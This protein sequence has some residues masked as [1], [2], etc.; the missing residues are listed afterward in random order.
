[1]AEIPS[2]FRT[3]TGKCEESALLDG[4]S[5]PPADNREGCEALTP[6]WRSILE[7]LQASLARSQDEREHLARALERTST[8][9]HEQLVELDALRNARGAAESGNLV[10]GQMLAMIGRSMRA[11]VDAVL[12][13]TELLRSGRLPSPQRSY[14]DAMR[15]A[16]ETLKATLDDVSDFSR[17]ESGTLPLEPIEFDV[18]VLVYDFAATLGGEAARRNVGLQVR[19]EREG[20]LRVTGDPGRIR[21]VLAAIVRDAFARL[22]GGEVTVTVT[23]DPARSDWSRT[24]IS[25]EDSGPA[26]PSDLLATIF[27][28][29]MPFESYAHPGGSL[30]LPIARQLAHLMGG[31]LVVENLPDSGSRFLLCLPLPP[32]RPTDSL[33]PQFDT[34]AAQGPGQPPRGRLLVVE[35]DASLRDNWIE[36]ARAAGY[37]PVGCERYSEARAELRRSSD[38]GCPFAVVVFSDHDA[39]AYADIG[40]EITEDHD[41]DKPALLMLP[42]VGNPGD[43]RRLRDAGFRGYLVKPVAPADLRETLETLRRTSRSTWHRLFLTRHALAEARRGDENDAGSSS[44]V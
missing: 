14:A 22:E 15:E 38:E 24:R 23:S 41:L 8:E 40:R 42:A 21:Q 18:R 5:K 44:S 39:E 10:R 36:I 35:A 6:G 32:V 16:A 43:G 9:L 26:I 1:M 33:Q 13:L 7:S 28:P 37:R 17:L 12:G 19:W 25:I 29:F 34:S 31:E 4:L 11:P 2:C 20:S 30:A 3:T 27:E